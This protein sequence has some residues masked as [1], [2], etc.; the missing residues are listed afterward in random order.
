VTTNFDEL[1]AIGKKNAQK[2]ASSNSR[3]MFFIGLAVVLTIL[4][5]LWAT[6][7]KIPKF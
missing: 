5:M 7:E 2:K 1:L 6:G 3:F 4:I